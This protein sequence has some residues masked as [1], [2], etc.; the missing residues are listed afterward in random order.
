MFPSDITAKRVTPLSTPIVIV[1]GWRAS[2]FSVQPRLNIPAAGLVRN[3]KVF[4]FSYD[5]LTLK[6]LNQPTLDK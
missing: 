6:K 5:Y 4:N 3:G 1:D 2:Y